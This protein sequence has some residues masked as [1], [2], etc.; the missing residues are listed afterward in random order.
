MLKSLEGKKTL[1]NT[2][3]VGI[4]VTKKDGGTFIISPRSKV[5]V[6]IEDFETLPKNIAVK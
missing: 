6:N 2:T 4:P 3:N 5:V 1:V